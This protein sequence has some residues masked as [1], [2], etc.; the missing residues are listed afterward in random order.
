M[1]SPKAK[2]LSTIMK[3]LNKMKKELHVLKNDLTSKIDVARDRLQA[4]EANKKTAIEAADKLCESETK[5]ANEEI[6]RL[7][8][9]H[10]KVENSLKAD[11]FK[12]LEV[13]VVEP[14]TDEAPVTKK[15][16]K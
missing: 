15:P 14:K 3:P 8:A 1:F 7:T 16:Q 10:V 6:A 4:A 11:I 12:V 5:S 9:E 2:P 13:P